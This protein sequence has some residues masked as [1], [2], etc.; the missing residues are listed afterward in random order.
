MYLKECMKAAGPMTPCLTEIGRSPAQPRTRQGFATPVVERVIGQL[1]GHTR[2]DWRDEGLA[3][4][5]ALRA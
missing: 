5:I 4:E 2:F 3:C 1:K